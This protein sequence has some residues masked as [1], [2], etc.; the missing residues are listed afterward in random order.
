MINWDKILKDFAYKC[1]GGAPDF[2]NSDHLNLLR[3][4][5]LKFGWKEFATNEFL[6][7]LREGEDK[8]YKGKGTRTGKPGEYKYDYSEPS[9]ERGGKKKDKKDE[10]GG[11][12]VASAEVKDE[13]KV[14]EMEETEEGWDIRS[15][16]TLIDS[17]EEKTDKVYLKGKSAP[18]GAEVQTGP[19]GGKYYMGNPETGEPTLK[20]GTPKS[21]QKSDEPTKKKELKNDI[22]YSGENT[23][24]SITNEITPTDDEFEEKKKNGKIKEQDYEND[25]IEVDGQTYPQPL[26]VEDIEKMFPSPPHKIPKRYIK[27]L[28]RILN[29]QREGK[30]NPPI[31]EFLDGVGAGE[32]PAQSAELLTLMA[33]SLD[34]EDAKKLFKV[35]EATSENQK[36]PSI[37]DKDWVQASKASRNAILRQVREK[38]GDDATIE[39][40][41][42]DVQSDVEDGIGMDDYKTNKG[43][44]TDAYFRVQTKDGPKVHEVSLKKDLDAFFAN[45]GSDG[46]QQKLDE[47]GIESFE[48]EDDLSV[49]EVKERDSVSNLTKNQRKRSV[50]R[51]GETK[52]E[53]VDKIV[54]KSEEQHI[55]D[56][57]NLPPGLRSLVLSGSPPKT[58]Y[59]LKPEAK[60]V[61]DFYNKLKEKHPLP[62]DAEKL[63][64]PD[65]RKEAK[66]A[67]FDV[68]TSKGINKLQVFTNYLIYS[69]EVANGTNDGPGFQFLNNQIGVD[70]DPPPGSAKDVA[71][72]HID[73][74]AKPES[75]K[76]LMELLREKFPLKSLMEGE[77]SMAL[78][79]QSLD[80]VTCKAIFGTDDYAEIEEGIRVETDED[81][82]KYLVYQAKT[83]GEVI[84]IGEVKCR[85]RGQGYAAPT[86]EIGPSEEFRHRMYC[87]NKDKI[88]EDDYTASEK[89][90]INR[91]T[92]KFGECGKA[93]Y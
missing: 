35:L 14:V 79:N 5:L 54:N 71:N 25:T 76:V 90:T 45:L 26:S 91:V 82:N 47:A 37:L 6:G 44:S 74:L 34:D 42:W 72:K 69:D 38:Y 92:K 13:G 48:A 88:K 52:Q 55:K 31:T 24:E 67:G 7:N 89:K 23:P 60:K 83:A 51:V 68:G 33:G 66:K 30:S 39:F 17:L 8:D 59:K 63:K 80:P 62:W 36:G 41:G 2:I 28:H 27:A 32:V 20:P 16:N 70:K 49:E 46:I 84:R 87:A 10:K 4:S 50:S 64:D 29:T 93:K 58:P 57:Q 77:E 1:K 81:G 9:S 61:L 75:R 73:N 86:T 85:Q 3:E 56:A 11:K 43:F 53:E 18:P 21:K 19:R 65:F 22:D 15:A 12:V 78:S 40:A